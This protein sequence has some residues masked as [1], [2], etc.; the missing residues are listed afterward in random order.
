MLIKP[1]GEVVYRH[2]DEIDPL[3]LRRLIIANL[4]DDDYIGHQAYWQ[5]K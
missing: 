2:Q 1:G 3:E 4:P 5:A